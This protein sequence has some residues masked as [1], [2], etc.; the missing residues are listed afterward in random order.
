MIFRYLSHWI[1]RK[2]T[3]FNAH[4][5]L[6]SEASGR[7]FGF[8]V[9]LNYMHPL[10]VRAENVLASMYSRVGLPC[11]KVIKL[12]SCSTQLSTIFILLINVKMPTIVGI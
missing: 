7:D 2:K 11:Q 12:F 8:S 3:P 4:A 6:S 9:H 10:L 1:W 5:G